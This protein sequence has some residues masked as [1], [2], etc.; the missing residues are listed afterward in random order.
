MR[1]GCVT[2]I[3]NN[4]FRVG[5]SPADVRQYVNAGHEVYI[6]A[7]AGIRSGF[8]DQEYE[9]QGAIVCDEAAKVW[10]RA[11]LIVKVKELYLKNMIMCEKDRSSLPIFT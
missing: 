4:E 7:G 8:T 10:E 6:E 2:E 9:D 1:I 5:M 3:M 11:E